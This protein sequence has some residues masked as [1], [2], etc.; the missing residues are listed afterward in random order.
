LVQ[1][2]QVVH[3]AQGGGKAVVDYAFW[4]GILLVVI[5]LVAAPIYRFVVTRLVHASELAVVSL[6]SF[7]TTAQTGWITGSLFPLAPS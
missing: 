6:D 3:Q 5:V 2:G 1:V 4:K 7:S